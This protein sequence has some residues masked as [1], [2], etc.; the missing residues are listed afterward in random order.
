[1]KFRSL[2]LRQTILSLLVFLVF[3]GAAP[4]LFSSGVGFFILSPLL[5][6]LLFLW[7]TVLRHLS[8]VRIKRLHASLWIISAAGFLACWFYFLFSLPLS[9]SISW[10]AVAVLLEILLAGEAV[11][12]LWRRQFQQAE[13]ARESLNSKNLLLS[14]L[15]HEIRTP[16]TVIRSGVG[17]LREER[18][19][20]L[21]ETQSRFLSSVAENINR[22]MNL[23]DN[24]ISALKVEGESFKLHRERQDVRPLLRSASELMKPY[25]EERGITLSYTYPNLISRAWMDAEWTQQILINLIHN[26]GKHLTP[27][28]RI[29][30]SALENELFL[31]VRVQDNGRG[32]G[33]EGMQRLFDPFYQGDNLTENH[34][35]G[36]G[37]GLAI[38]K[39]IVQ[40]QGGEIYL[41]SSEFLGTSVSFT[42]PK[43]EVMTHE[44][45]DSDS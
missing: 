28:G 38:V 33:E 8:S 32:I 37:L 9:R 44:A 35:D 10:L 12:R 45:A 26:A 41:G 31:V 11:Y 29:V 5:L 14:T 15:A 2:L 13:A 20:P 4:G 19:G 21:N 36:A 23:S 42:L 3:A 7:R 16:L 17:L 40:R 25:L 6:L 1:M 34:F 27:G 43:K 39:K 30:V 18:P 24:L 22:L